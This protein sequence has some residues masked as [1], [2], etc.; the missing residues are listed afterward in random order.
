VRGRLTASA[1]T[2]RGKLG[3]TRRADGTLQATYGGRP[4]YYYV[5]DRRPGQVLCQNVVEYGGRWLVLRAD[6]RLVR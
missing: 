5:G 2:A 1:G 4:L 3:T 6:G